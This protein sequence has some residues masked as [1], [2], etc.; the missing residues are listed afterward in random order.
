M[1]E[2]IAFF[3]EEKANCFSTPSALD[4]GSNYII[5]VNNN[6]QLMIQVSNN[7]NMIIN[8]RDSINLNTKESIKT[9]KMLEDNFIFLITDLNNVYLLETSHDYSVVLNVRQIQFR[10]S[11]SL[12][13][14]SIKNENIKR[15]G[16][17]WLIAADRFLFTFDA[18]SG[19]F[20][21]FK[22]LSDQIINYCIDQKDET[23]VVVQT[24][25]KVICLKGTMTQNKWNAEVVYQKE[26]LHGK[27]IHVFNNKIVLLNKDNSVEIR[28]SFNFDLYYTI[29][30]NVLNQKEKTVEN[31]VWIT[32][33]LLGLIGKDYSYIINVLSNKIEQIIRSKG[34]NCILINEQV[35]YLKH[36]EA[37]ELTISSLVHHSYN[38][39]NK[40][41]KFLSKSL[42]DRVDLAFAY[43]SKMFLKKSRIVNV[44]E[45]I[46]EML[47]ELHLGPKIL[48]H[49]RFKD[50]VISLFGLVKDFTIC[51]SAG[52][53][54]YKIIKPSIVKQIESQEIQK[55][56]NTV[57]FGV[58]K[59]K[60]DHNREVVRILQKDVKIHDFAKSKLIAEPASSYF[61]VAMIKGDLEKEEK[62]LK[63]QEAN[64]QRESK[65]N[66]HLGTLKGLCVMLIMSHLSSVAIYRKYYKPKSELTQYYIN[67]C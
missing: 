28:N 26:K 51:D 10:Y 64:S 55:E 54:I 32:S 20:G 14:H 13:S 17:S 23:L 4:I 8:L 44:K 47:M 45:S 12:S 15:L 9:A 46:Q 62:S 30:L 49:K 3:R 50:K 2:N 61:P 29:S 25:S 63:S 58:L 19:L 5:S 37:E 18:V 33:H 41:S 6:N 57:N 34:T 43:I 67:S 22:I 66:P 38:S 21:I 1:Q 11:S 56:S 24:G 48:N 40:I 53:K 65:K 36:R 7:Q 52:L 35:V 39:E 59:T 60:M 31:V 27:K 42:E 16:D